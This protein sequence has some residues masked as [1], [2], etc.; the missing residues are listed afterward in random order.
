MAFDKRRLSREIA[1]ARKAALNA[2]LAEL[3]S[4]IKTARAE[5]HAAIQ[6]VRLDCKAKREELR[7]ACALRR[8]EASELGLRGVAR[9]QHV[10]SHERAEARAEEALGKR[11]R[12]APTKKEKDAE[13]DC[14]VRHN[15]APELVP[16]FDAVRKHIKGSP[17]KSRTEAFLEWAT[18]NPG[19]VYTLQQR[20]A[21]R[22]LARLI[23][24]QEQHY[25]SLARRSAVP[26]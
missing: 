18:E 2:R 8:V 21:D 24:E 22:D 23:A 13:S 20:D 19:E 17:R 14:A 3:R 5:R 1:A 4:L 12:K 15:L 9:A 11:P 10:F 7:S 16:V 25:R 26:F 6:G